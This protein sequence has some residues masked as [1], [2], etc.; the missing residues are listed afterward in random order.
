MDQLEV[1]IGFLMETK[2]TGG[3]YTRH[4]SGYDVLASNA[5]SSS[6]GGIALFWRGNISYEV[7]ETR[8]W[9]PNVISLHLMLGA[10]RFFVVGC[11]IPPNDLEA[12]ACVNK[13]WRECPAG[14]HPILVGDLNV[15]LRAPRTEREET[16]AEQ[17]DAMDLVDMSRHFRQRSGK[18]LRGRWTWRMRREGRWISSQCDYFLGRET[19]RRRFRRVSVRMPRYHSDHRALVA[20]IYAERGGN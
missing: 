10:T 19:D 18:R 6:S 5:T 17:V 3:I 8:I 2:L 16:I 7:E 4:S 13:A 11:Y 20:V 1:D 14:A 9:G 12:L 15:N